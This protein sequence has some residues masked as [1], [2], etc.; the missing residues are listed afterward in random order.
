MTN[1]NLHKN[2][3]NKS[4]QADF[5]DFIKKELGNYHY[6]SKDK[7]NLDVILELQPRKFIALDSLK[8]VFNGLGYELGRMDSDIENF[9]NEIS[10]SS[11]NLFQ[12]FN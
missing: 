7:T 9:Q 1:K 8:E 12:K 11:L 2:T 6:Y 3:K 10:Y 4:L 5:E